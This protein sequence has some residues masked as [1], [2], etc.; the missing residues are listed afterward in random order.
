MHKLNKESRPYN[1]N[2][3][4]RKRQESMNRNRSYSRNRQN[5]PRSHQSR[6]EGRTNPDKRTSSRNQ[7]S[8]REEKSRND[9]RH[10]RK[11]K[12]DKR[13]ENS[14]GDSR[15]DSGHDS[16]HDSRNTRAL[17]STAHDKQ[18]EAEL[19][20]IRN[21]ESKTGERENNEP[22][23][24]DKHKYDAQKYI[25]KGLTKEEALTLINSMKTQEKLSEKMKFQSKR[26]H[27]GEQH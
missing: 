16:R 23:M 26:S 25:D 10:K 21:E 17:N 14:G 7:S 22:N 27:D 3:E 5:V 8:N 13:Q 24:A 4:H 18:V 19:K 12:E 11:M 20:R 1:N 15:H 2:N 6:A 9:D